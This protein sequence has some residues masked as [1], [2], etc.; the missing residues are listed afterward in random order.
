MI[1]WFD[2]QLRLSKTPG[3]QLVNKPFPSSI[4]TNGN[5]NDCH[6]VFNNI[7]NN[8]NLDFNIIVAQLLK[9]HRCATKTKSA[10]TLK[11]QKVVL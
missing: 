8:N 11:M 6:L 2:F 1:K 10:W 3:G 9:M 7:D 5:H 4:N